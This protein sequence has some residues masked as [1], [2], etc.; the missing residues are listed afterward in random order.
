MQAA[1]LHTEL[2]R[3]LDRIDRPLTFC[4]RLVPDR[5]FPSLTVAGVGTIALPLDQTQAERLAKIGD[6][7][8][9]G[10]GTQT[11]VD[12][13]VRRVLRF[14]PA[15]FRLENP[16]WAEWIRGVVDLVSED[17]DLANMGL[18]AH[19]HELLLYRTGDFFLPHRDGEKLPGMVATMAVVLPARFTGGDVVVRH[20][21]ETET[22][23]FDN[24]ADAFDIQVAAW[25]ADCEHEITPL[26]AGNRLVLIYNLTLS[27]TSKG[28]QAPGFS[29]E[30]AGLANVLQRYRNESEQGDDACVAILLAH[31]YSEAGLSPALLKGTDR[32]QALALFKAAEQSGF[33]AH[34]AIL[35]HREVGDA[36]VD[37]YDN[38]RDTPRH[39]EMGEIYDRELSAD[40]WVDAAGT[41]VA[42]G[43]MAV[44]EH[45]IVGGMDEMKQAVSE[46]EFE[47][48]TGN[49]GMELTRWYHR[50][51]IILWPEERHAERLCATS[52]DAGIAGLQQLLNGS[53]AKDASRRKARH[54]ATAIL[55]RW[56]ASP[57][58][59]RRRDERTAGSMAGLLTTLGEVDLAVRYVEETLTIDPRETPSAGVL[60]LAKR[61]GWAPLAPAFHKLFTASQ[62][63]TLERNCALLT[64]LSQ[65]LSSDADSSLREICGTACNALIDTLLTTT[66]EPPRQPFS[67]A[68]VR[69]DMTAVQRALVSALYRLND[70]VAMD[71]LN[72]G[73]QDER[74]PVT[75]MQVP[76]IRILL[77]DI[78]LLSQW[79]P[80][81]SWL[82]S[83][84]Q[85]L[86]QRVADEPQLPKSYA[87]AGLPSC[88]CDDCRQLDAFLRDPTAATRRFAMRESRR[89]HLAEV[90]AL[91]QCDLACT[92][93]TRGSPHALVCT[94][95]LASHERRV[96]Q[97]QRERNDL[98][99]INQ[100]LQHAPPR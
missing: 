18:T 94:K 58:L 72:R 100:A 45:A 9:Y 73:L 5:I 1:D 28:L 82:V 52:I 51:A 53:V 27:G 17:F 70:L 25:Y 65:E 39:V 35:T 77:T 11:V 48:Y 46:Q 21:G 99:L 44:P 6:P 57:T 76:V 41:T 69:V 81:Q 98:M 10:K 95:T 62:R 26:T 78:P 96:Q 4:T 60:P 64:T 19:L 92:T 85:D 87:R 89:R 55:D 32:A 63:D 47:G 56:R 7:A 50:A 29:P 3:H 68:V 13:R 90:I 43:T 34:L 20:D 71:R 24:E 54:L 80:F 91:H 93:E 88:D 84:Q 67:H 61:F 22:L 49:A 74:F 2:S 37:D 16:Q 8:A 14:A 97:L 83:C 86:T 31:A 75:D 59:H 23:S 38:Y 42:F 66:A 36:L 79:P 12:P 40:T 33:E 15:Q 30:I